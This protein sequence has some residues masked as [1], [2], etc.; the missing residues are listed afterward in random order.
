M[1]RLMNRCH[2]VISLTGKDLAKNKRKML[3]FQ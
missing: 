3:V 1:D 2:G